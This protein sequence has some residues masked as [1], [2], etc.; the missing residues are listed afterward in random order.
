TSNRGSNP[1]RIAR[2]SSSKPTSSITPCPQSRWAMPVS[3]QR[4]TNFSIGLVL[5]KVSGQGQQN[6]AHGNHVTGLDVDCS[7]SAI[8]K[9]ADLGFHFHGFQNAES[10]A[11]LDLLPRLHQYLANNATQWSNYRFATTQTSAMS[12]A[13][14]RRITQGNP[15]GDIAARSHCHCVG[16]AFNSHCINCVALGTGDQFASG[17][18][19]LKS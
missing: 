8:F 2:N 3:C 1:L 14:I 4:R 15:A 17:R 10:I 19:G 7:Y 9:T 11:D 16:L 6:V 13:N 5:Y 12:C 18:Y